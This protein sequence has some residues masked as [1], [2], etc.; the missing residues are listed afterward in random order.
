MYF[1][2]ALDGVRCAKAS[3]IE[4]SPLQNEAR[5]ESKGQSDQDA[6]AASQNR[7][8]LGILRPRL[9]SRLLE[10]GAGPSLGLNHTTVAGRW[11]KPGALVLELPTS[12]LL[13]LMVYTKLKGKLG[14]GLFH[15]F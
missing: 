14:A 9:R 15:H 1:R 5:F 10:I 8:V 4:K 13:V 6:M 3:D 12:G 7:K 11:W 2:I